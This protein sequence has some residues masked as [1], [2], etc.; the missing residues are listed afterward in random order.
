MDHPE[1]LIL[2]L[3]FRREATAFWRERRWSAVSRRRLSFHESQL[4]RATQWEGLLSRR[5]HRRVDPPL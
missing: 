2:R 3:L 1:D 4:F 5:P